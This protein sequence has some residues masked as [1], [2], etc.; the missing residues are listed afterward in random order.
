MATRADPG[1]G[2]GVSGYAITSG[3]AAAANL[4]A[5]VPTHLMSQV[6]P[7]RID[8]IARVV[9]CDELAAHATV[10]GGH[11]LGFDVS[12]MADFWVETYS[13]LSVDTLPHVAL[14]ADTIVL[15]ADL[16]Q[17]G[18]RAVAEGATGSVDCSHL[19]SATLPVIRSGRANAVLYWFRLHLDRA[20]TNV[21]VTGPT[22]KTSGGGIRCPSWRQAAV[23]QSGAVGVEL[24]AGRPITVDCVCR[25][26]HVGFQL[27]QQK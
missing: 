19:G 1:V 23:L 2:A 3:L 27:R 10:A 12:A 15:S 9:A 7:A 5:T 14:T 6:L 16:T 21:L 20:G 26:R 25:S 18:A 4:K 24:Q 11:V 17:L 8:V 22:S 13:E